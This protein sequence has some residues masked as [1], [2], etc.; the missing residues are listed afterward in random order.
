[1]DRQPPHASGLPDGGHLPDEEAHL[2]R[3]AR[4]RAW[5]PFL[6]TVALG[7]ALL[8]WC[9]AALPDLPEQ[10]PTHWGPDGTADAW[11]EKSFGAVAV[12][13][14][15]GLG[16]AAF[17]ALIAALLPAMTHGTQ[18]RSEWARLR[19]VGLYFG[20]VSAL[21]WISLLV[22]LASAPTTLQI[23]LDGSMDL[24]WWL[25]PLTM[26]AVMLGVFGV[27]SLTMRRW[28]RWSEHTATALGHRASEE[29]R[30]EEERW[31]P[32]GLKNDPDDPNIMVNKREGYGV[33][34][35]VNIGSR[36][37]RLLYRGF[38][39]LFAVGLPAILWITAW[40]G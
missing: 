35:T 24:P 38:L 23:L 15:I 3:R 39:A 13:P 17:M 36:G 6:V 4:P 20:M 8:V 40:P 29:E 7:V 12:G 26:T 37:G 14:L 18:D 28:H 34:A 1:M 30:A 19:A 25:M 22:L 27:L 9:L 31:T 2:V 5:L 11:S 33:G 21:G 32:T 16:T 10:I